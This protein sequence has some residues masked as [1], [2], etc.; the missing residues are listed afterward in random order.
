MDHS[1]PP[2]PPGTGQSLPAKFRCAI[3]GL[4]LAVRLEKNYR[5]HVAVAAAVVVAGAALGATLVDWCILGLCMALVLAIETLNTA[6]EHLAK[7]VA[8][9][10]NEHVGRAL[11]IA[12]G[13]VLLAAAAAAIVGGLVLTNRLAIRLG[14]WAIE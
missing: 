3:R 5:V 14:W 2:S 1:P 6:L 11:D 12:A 13:A 8:E 4:A 7:A 9:R 10:P